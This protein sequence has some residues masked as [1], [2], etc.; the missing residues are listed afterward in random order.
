MPLKGREFYGEESKGE[1]K[2]QIKKLQAMS[3]EQKKKSDFVVQVFS[4]QPLPSAFTLAQHKAGWIPE[5]PMGHH[6]CLLHQPSSFFTWAST[7]L[8]AEAVFLP[9]T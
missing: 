2:A 9:A 5:K 1:K 7:I 8:I 4:P 3:L 6:R